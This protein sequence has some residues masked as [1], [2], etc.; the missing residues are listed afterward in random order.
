MVMQ[1]RAQATHAAIIQAALDL[2]EDS[3]YGST[4]LT[5]I[6]NKAAVT[7]GAFYYH[8]HTRNRSP[9]P[10]SRGRTRKSTG[11]SSRPSRLRPA[12]PSKT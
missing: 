11:C 9:P 3:G 8:F 12:R 10:S 6:I 4:G 5:D 7:K 1:A 2:F